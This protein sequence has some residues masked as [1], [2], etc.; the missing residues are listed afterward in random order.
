[1]L[2]GAIEIT[3]TGH[4]AQLRRLVTE[5]IKTLPLLRAIRDVETLPGRPAASFSVN[6]VHQGSFSLVYTR[7]RCVIALA[8][9][10]YRT[11]TEARWRITLESMSRATAGVVAALKAEEGLGG[12]YDE[13]HGGS[14]G[15]F[16]ADTAGAVLLLKRMDEVV[17]ACGG[18]EEEKAVEE[19]GGSI[20]VEEATKAEPEVVVLE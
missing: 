9:A 12:R 19:G 20:V 10:A 4:A 7:P 14:P 1:M 11:G 2:K 8:A 17:W 5:L 18:E 15:G 6:F 3:T 13:W 16:V